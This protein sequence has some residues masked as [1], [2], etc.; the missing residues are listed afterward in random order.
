MSLNCHLEAIFLV[1]TVIILLKKKQYY[2][3]II[4]EVINSIIKGRSL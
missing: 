3:G 2:L 1:A 4:R